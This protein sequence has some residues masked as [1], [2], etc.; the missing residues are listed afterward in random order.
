MKVSNIFSISTGGK[1][2]SRCS[3]CGER[4]DKELS[5]LILM[6]C[7]DERCG[8]IS[9]GKLCRVA[10]RDEKRS[11]SKMCKGVR[12]NEPEVIG[13]FLKGSM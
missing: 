11:G 7:L 1:D 6:T 13:F 5:D 10:E 2:W 12:N 9:G 4:M 3:F 8:K